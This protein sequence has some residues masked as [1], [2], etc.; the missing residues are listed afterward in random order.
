MSCNPVNQFRMKFQRNST[1]I[2]LLAIMLVIDFKPVSAD[3]ELP[4]RRKEQFQ[5]GSGHY[6]I[7]TPYSIPGLGD[8]FLIAGAITN[9]NDS[10]TDIYGFAAAGDIEGYGVFAT[11]L[12][13][14]D[15]TLILDLS[16]NSFSKATSQVYPARGMDTDANDYVLAELDRN[17]FSGARLTY[18]LYD[19]RLEFY[20]LVYRNKSRLAAIRDQEGNLIQFAD[21]PGSDTSESVTYGVR[22]DLTDD[23]T[24]PRKGIR[25]ETSIW[26]S[27]AS[28]RSN[29]DYDILELNLTGYIPMR[30]RDTLVLNYFQAGTDVNRKGET[31]P[32]QI[33]AELGIDCD[34]LSADLQTDCQSI[35]NNEVAQNT[36]GSVG[37]LGGLSRLRSFP[38]NRFSGSQVRFYGIEY[39]WNLVEESEPFDYF[40]AKDIRT[41][42]QLAAFYERGAIADSKSELDASMRD[43][44]GIGARLVTQSGLIFRADWAT[45]DEG[46]ELSIIFGYPWEIF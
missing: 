25:F 34:L 42:F 28:D 31:D 32:D 37:S 33:E 30:S 21:D 23:Y 24:D 26:H 41:V 39:R 45:G 16:A 13:L 5:K 43:S 6:V 12:H 36:Y 35:V 18:S 38:D 17:D 9:I 11:E 20:G 1:S 40:L 14:L 15:R 4:D 22:F 44:W 2:L 27:P 7:P 46:D 19:R 3:I 29:P 10:Y 8:G